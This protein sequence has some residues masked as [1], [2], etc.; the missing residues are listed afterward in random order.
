MRDEAFEKA[1]EDAYRLLKQDDLEGAAA[2]VKQR[3]PGGSLE[4]A[5][6]FAAIAG[7]AGESGDEEEARKLAGF[8]YKLNPKSRVAQHNF[9]ASLTILAIRLIDQKQ[10]EEAGFLLRKALG[11]DSE[12]GLANSEYG[13]LLGLLNRFEE[14]KPYIK[15][16]I[17]LDPDDAVNYGNYAFI[18]ESEGN[19]REAEKHLNMA[20]KLSPRE[21]TYHMRL[22]SL[23][24]LRG[25]GEEARK[26][27]ET[28][29]KLNPDDPL[30][31]RH[32]EA[33]SLMED[34]TDLRKPAITFEKAEKMGLLEPPELVEKQADKYGVAF[35][36]DQCGRCCKEKWDIAV[37]GKDL[38]KWVD[39]HLDEALLWL[40]FS[41]K[42]FTHIG[43]GVLDEPYIIIDNGYDAL[44][45]GWPERPAC[46]FLIRK[47]GKA[48]CG[49]HKVKPETCRLY[50]FSKGR[51]GF[52]H[53]R[54]RQ[55]DVCSCVREYYRKL[56]ENTGIPQ[57]KLMEDDEEEETEDDG[58]R[59]PAD[60][61]KGTR[62]GYGKFIEYV[63][64]NRALQEKANIILEVSK[65]TYRIPLASSCGLN[66]LKGYL[67]SDLAAVK[68][69]LRQRGILAMWESLERESQDN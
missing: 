54:P 34:D 13:R 60:E 28:A 47:N 31:K 30:F 55:A 64:R 56:S 12:L 46:R 7:E 57:Q 68:D 32:L 43:G 51:D 14:A 39:L 11:V 36:C 49:I 24:A 15:K 38:S 18:L 65:G 3:I 53:I 4:A 45:F 2:V 61:T 16:A 6:F 37:E 52:L 27:A 17:K 58:R 9:A 59:L 66:V 22:S 20:V 63:E 67:N 25:K 42:W 29:A 10:F 44:F 62:E 69:A 26:S 23:L 1:I 21:A 41:P 50:P 19:F 8:A 35:N 5:D 48:Y 40:V 33:I